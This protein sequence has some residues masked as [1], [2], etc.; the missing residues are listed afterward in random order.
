MKNIYGSLVLRLCMLPSCVH[1]PIHRRWQTEE[2]AQ[3]QRTHIHVADHGLP[4][5]HQHVLVL[6][7]LLLLRGQ[8][9]E[10]PKDPG[11]GPGERTSS[12]LR[13]SPAGDTWKRAPPGCLWTLKKTQRTDPLIPKCQVAASPEAGFPVSKRNAPP[14]IFLHPFC[15]AW[16][17][18]PEITQPLTF[19]F[20]NTKPNFS[21]TQ[22]WPI[23]SWLDKDV[24]KKSCFLKKTFSTI[25]LKPWNILTAQEK[26]MY[27]FPCSVLAQAEVGKEIF[28]FCPRADWPDPA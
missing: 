14:A 25:S 15:N 20:S 27:G 18:S 23:Y 10:R 4:L 5:P 21:Q 11:P 16:E 9:P 3:K 7:F 24:R 26:Y 2:Q 1:D 19:S 17:M 8:G 13:V 6:L 22:G 28:F 12:P